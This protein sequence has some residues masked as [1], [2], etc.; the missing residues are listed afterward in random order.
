MYHCEKRGKAS[1][2]RKREKIVQKFSV[3]EQQ[4]YV[5][6][7]EDFRHRPKDHC[8]YSESVTMN[9]HLSVAP[10]LWGDIGSHLCWQVDCSRNA[11]ATLLAAMTLLFLDSRVAHARLSVAHAP[12]CFD[13]CP[14]CFEVVKLVCDIIYYYGNRTLSNKETRRTK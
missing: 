10:K 6:P 3:Q 1:C 8:F 13:H 7:I 4:Q 11:N 5:H 14:W 9:F 12:V 2:V